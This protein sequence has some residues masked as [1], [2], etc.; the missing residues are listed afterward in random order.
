MSD[1]MDDVQRQWVSLP[2]SSCDVRTAAG[3]LEHSG[4]LFRDTVG[5][6]RAC[7][8]VV[9]EGVDEPLVERLR[10]QLVGAGFEFGRCDV[11]PQLDVQKG[12][13]LM[14]AFERARITSDDLVCALGG[15]DLM[16][17]CAWACSQWCGGTP[18][19]CVP[20]SGAALLDGSIVPRHLAVGDAAGTV[21]VKPCAKRAVCDLDVMDMD[22]D[23]DANR[24]VRVLMVATAMSESERSFS[25]LWD[26]ADQI[27][28]GDTDTWVTQ[29]HETAKGRGHLISSSSLAMRQSVDYGRTFS[30]ALLQVAPD[31]GPLW[32]RMSEGMRFLGRV[33]VGLGKLSVDDMLAQDDLLGMLGVD[34]LTKASPDPDALVNALKQQRFRVSNRF[35]L[36]VPQAIGRVRLASVDDDLLHEHASAWCAA[37]AQAAAEDSATGKQADGQA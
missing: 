10:R 2:G 20:L 33:A 28:A 5:T 21:R 4:K 14:G 9:E 8:L 24:L 25:Q 27:M 30:A 15:A 35:L 22:P 26:R 7:L 36:D 3:I 34:G 11:I 1:T 13:S 37:H 17:L 31:A 18:L 12:V 29:L 23:S 16:A 32:L 6:P 19:V